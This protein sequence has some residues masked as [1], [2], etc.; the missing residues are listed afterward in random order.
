MAAKVI[1]KT[2]DNKLFEAGIIGSHDYCIEL[3]NNKKDFIGKM[4][5]IMYQNLTSDEKVPRFGKMKGI[6]YD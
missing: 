1:L 5:T 4:A 2:K 3:F 6:K